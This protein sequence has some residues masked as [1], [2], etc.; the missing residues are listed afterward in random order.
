MTRFLFVLPLA[1]AALLAACGD[2]PDPPPSPTPVATATPTRAPAASV[3]TLAPGTPVVLQNPITTA[4]GLKYVDV[5]VGTGES[6]TASSPITIN[7]AGMFAANG[8]VFDTTAGREP[9][10]SPRADGFIPG[11][12]EALLGMKEGGKR[13][14]FIPS[15]LAYGSKGY[16]PIPPNVDLIFQIELLK[17][18]E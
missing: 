5:V 12:T 4:S 16:G 13:D 1:V 9:Y 7:Y 18:G 6:P 10:S 11:F 15:N 14:V 2:G 17:V 3:A 8:L